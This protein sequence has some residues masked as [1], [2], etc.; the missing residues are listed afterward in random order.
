M[1]ISAKVLQSVR[2]A[3]STKQIVGSLYDPYDN[4]QIADSFIYDRGGYE[5]GSSY[6]YE[7]GM[8]IRIHPSFAIG[9]A[10]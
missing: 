4:F 2:R 5:H 3:L 8:L 1:D 10:T 6:L 7:N 9:A